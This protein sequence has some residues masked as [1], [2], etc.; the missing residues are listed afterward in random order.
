MNKNKK[1]AVFCILVVI[2]VY[3]ACQ[4]SSACL[5]VGTLYLPQALKPDHHFGTAPAL[6]ITM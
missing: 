6:E 4:M 5:S 1:K 3:Y 2:D